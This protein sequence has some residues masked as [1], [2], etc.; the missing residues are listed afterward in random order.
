MSLFIQAMKRERFVVRLFDADEVQN[1]QQITFII[2]DILLVT[3]G[4]L[5]DCNRSFVFGSHLNILSMLL[6]LKEICSY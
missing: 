5:G 2:L 4:Y 3:F 1:V 6:W